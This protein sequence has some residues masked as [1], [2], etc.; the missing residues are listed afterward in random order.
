MGQKRIKRSRKL[1]KALAVFLSLVV[2][3]DAIYIFSLLGISFKLNKLN[4][5]EKAGGLTVEEISDLNDS[6]IDATLKDMELR[7]S[8][9]PPAEGNVL[10]QAD[11]VNILVCG[12]DMPQPGT[13]DLGRCDA[14]VIVSLNKTTGDIKLIS[15]ERSIGV[16]LPG[17]YED[18]K[19]NNAFNYGGGAY[20][21]EVLSQCFLV[22]LAGYVHL[23]YDTIPQVF[24]AIGGIEVE[25]DQSEVYNISRFIE[26]EKDLP[27][28]HV[29]I[30]TLTGWAAYGYCRLRNSDNNWAR[31]S[32]VRNALQAMV[33]KLKTM[34]IADLN[35]MADTVLPLIGTNLTKDEISS[36]ILSSPTFINAKVEQMAVPDKGNNWSYQT[37]RGEHMLGLDFSEWS[38]KIRT[39]IYGDTL[40]LN[41]RV[42]NLEAHVA[43]NGESGEP[44]SSGAKEPL[45]FDARSVFS[46]SDVKE[47]S[48]QGNR[49][50]KTLRQFLICPYGSVQ[51]VLDDSFTRETVILDEPGKGLLVEPGL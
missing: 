47:G 33:K 12:T 24:D 13:K 20:I 23:P 17:N 22:D 29:G 6:D 9:A 51:V 27:K 36:L 11:V 42:V 28:P 15:F 2:V 48:G 43:E 46:V 37:G 41:Y 16:P 40:S 39:F 26:Y 31:Q 50:Y 21:Q 44:A 34:S 45:P 4:Y 10:R 19:L 38:R 18:T 3:V 32:R 25:L 14:A 7:E 8:A 5:H 1:L 30:N 49:A 35:N